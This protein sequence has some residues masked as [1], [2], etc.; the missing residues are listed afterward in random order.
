MRRTAHRRR[1][2][3]AGAVL[4]GAAWLTPARAQPCA[5][6]CDGDGAV[7]VAEL[8]AAVGITLGTAP[9]AA[10]ASGD[11]DGD[12]QVTV[13]EL[14]R[15]VNAALDGCPPPPPG[16]ALIVVERLDLQ[17]E[18]IEY[19]DVRRRF[20]IG[21]RTTGVIH[22]V[23]DA[24]RLTVAVGAPGLGSTLGLHIDRR[25]SRLL[26]AGSFAPGGISGAETAA[27]GMYDLA[28]GAVQRVVDLTR[29]TPAG[30][31]LANDVVTDA[32]GNA[33]VTDT[34]IGTI[35][36]VSPDGDASIFAAG[37]ALGLPNGIELHDD[38]LL[39][40]G[41]LLGPS[42]IRIPLDAP[43]AARAVAGATV[44]GDGLVLTAGG[45]LAVVGGLADAGRVLRVESTD[46]WQSAQ[47]TATWDASAVSPSPPTTAARR[48][49]GL[50]VIFAHLFQPAHA[51]YEIARVDF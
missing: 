43:A 16:P 33:Y 18:G 22:A 31:H 38:R 17:P 42:L 36:R 48:G 41:T 10:C 25:G 50:H 9:L 15:A 1:A 8:I 3:V 37:P 35:Y 34:L 32:A 20:L 28:S 29:L 39:L 51:Q 5:G 27:L 4:L 13:D 24:G 46:D 45:A 26:A 30:P 40:V 12:G 11:G 2:A 7:V 49:D 44:S 23:D 19:D 6:D 14:I 21:S 47:V